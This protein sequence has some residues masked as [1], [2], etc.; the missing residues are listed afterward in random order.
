MCV[1]AAA[2][3]GNA[4][5]AAAALAWPVW[6]ARA[7]RHPGPRPAAQK[8]HRDGRG[9]QQQ[10]QQ[11]GGP[12][13]PA[14]CA[15][16]ASH[17]STNHLSARRASLFGAPG[18]RARGRQSHSQSVDFVIRGA[19]PGPH[20]RGGAG[21]ARDCASASRV[22]ASASASCTGGAFWVSGSL[23]WQFNL[24]PALQLCSASERGPAASTG[25]QQG[26]QRGT[27][28]T[29]SKPPRHHTHPPT[30]S[31]CRA[32]RARPD[33]PAIGQPGRANCA[34][35][36]QGQRSS[37]SPSL[38]LMCPARSPSQPASQPGSCND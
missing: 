2:Q 7:A 12:H 14:P 29:Q 26:P 37:Q 16:C 13:A 28:L 10:R 1:A 35:A 27:R 17:P 25:G 9:A 22:A 33:A 3:D 38:S 15:P 8:T 21:G 11:R 18:A 31:G 34:H 5:G 4:S 20:T 36:M 6:R 23:V 32:A 24:T 30:R 19:M